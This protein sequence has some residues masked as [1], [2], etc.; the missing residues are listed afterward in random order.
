MAARSC[1]ACDLQTIEDLRRKLRSRGKLMVVATE[2]QQEAALRRRSVCYALCK[3]HL[4]ADEY[5]TVCRATNMDQLRA[6]A[7][8]IVAAG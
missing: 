1:S 7:T 4:A 5:P 8:A 2:G 3:E 6:A